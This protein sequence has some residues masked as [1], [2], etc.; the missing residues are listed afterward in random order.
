MLITQQEALQYISFDLPLVPYKDVGNEVQE[1][2][3]PCTISF[4]DRQGEYI[5]AAAALSRVLHYMGCYSLRNGA[6]RPLPDDVQS[7]LLLS[8]H[9]SPNS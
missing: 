1:D 2:F 3:T 7:T 9:V 6:S 5:P 4:T 8:L